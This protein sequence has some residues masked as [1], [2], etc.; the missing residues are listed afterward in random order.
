MVRVNEE[1]SKQK[2]HISPGDTF[3]DCRITDSEL[4]GTG[5]RFVGTVIEDCDCDLRHSRMVDSSVVRCRGRV[6]Q[7]V[8]PQGCCF[9]DNE[10]Y[11]LDMDSGF[12]FPM[13][14][15]RGNTSGPYNGPA[16]LAGFIGVTPEGWEPIK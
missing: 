5:G 6:R 15:C 3:V 4:R 10:Y 16:C 1:L 7:A 12:Q 11:G 14:S 13:S 2:I 8:M 9:I